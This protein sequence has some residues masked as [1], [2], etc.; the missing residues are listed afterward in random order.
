MSGQQI[1]FGLM[2][3]LVSVFISFILIFGSYRL[4][5]LL[6]PKLDE[7]RQLKKKNVSIGIV[8]GGIFLGE[9][10]IVRE[11]I[12]PVMAVIQIYVLGE[13]HNALNFFK[14]LGFSIGYVLLSGIL[15][16]VSILF[17]LW[18]FNKMTPRLDELEEIKNNNV[19]I[20]LFVALFVLAICLLMS[21][22]V[23]GLT[24]ALI[25]FPEIGTMPFLNK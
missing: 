15:A 24:R 11:A 18:I 7:E 9:A 14:M 13:E 1:I 5:L 8:L 10:I 4:F 21:S 19:A 12:Y 22:G 17:S 3:F 6:T 20:A 23:A 16:L 25:P 2:N